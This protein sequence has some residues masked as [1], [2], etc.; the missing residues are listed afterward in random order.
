MLILL[1]VILNILL[2][3]YVSIGTDILF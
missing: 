1:E 3:L 2:G